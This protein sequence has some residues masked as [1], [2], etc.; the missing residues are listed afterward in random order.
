MNQEPGATAGLPATVAGAIAAVRSGRAT[1]L[2][3]WQRHV[4]R[5]RATH[6]APGRPL[7]ALVQPRHEAARLEAAAIDA[8]GGGPLAGVMA[9]VKECFAVEGLA[10]TLGLRSRM[11]LVDEASGEM[12]RRLSE[13]GAV[14]VGKA[15]VPQA[16]LQFDSDNPVWGRTLHPSSAERGPGGSSG[17]DAALVAAGVVPL[18][19]GTDLA[20][21]MRQPAH[22][23][24]ITSILPSSAALGPCETFDTMPHLTCVRPRAGFF[25]RSVEDLAIVVDAILGRQAGLAASNDTLP[26]LRIG[27]WDETG[28]IPPS[29]AVR[30]GVR[31]AVGRLARAGLGPVAVSPTLAHEA[32]WLHLAIV[33]SDGGRAIR[34]LFGGER[35]LAGI[36]RNLAMARLPR[37]VRPA[38]SAAARLAGRDLESRAL[39]ETG[40]RSRRAFEDLVSRR[41]VIRDRMAREWRDAA[42]RPLDAIVCPV[43]ALPALRHQTAHAF[44]LA[45]MPCFLANLL[46]LPA[47]V[48]PVTRVRHDECHGRGRSRDPLLRLAA[49]TDE[50]SE[51]LP[52]GVQVIAIDGR[53]ATAI[54]VMRRLEGDWA[55]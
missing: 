54:A 40:P 25:A 35:P 34:D 22:A 36:A 42:G 19:V 2:D 44:M 8:R 33:S 13:A 45:G 6:A 18:A 37:F 21:S 32:A 50:G 43:F 28:P 5:Y 51:G 14:V 31:E 49:A 10:T 24:G 16:M 38:L 48:V 4:D 39:L 23:C 9:S 47:G 46:D 30:R 1:V 55:D 27:W 11:G 52:I 7:N 53:E 29:P 17:G 3:F 41:E 20:G 26:P 12:V 15:N